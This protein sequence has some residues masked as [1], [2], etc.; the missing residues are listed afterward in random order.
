MLWFVTAQSPE[1]RKQSAVFPDCSQWRTPSAQLN[2][3]RH[4]TAG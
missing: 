2:T 1:G 3:L 4:E